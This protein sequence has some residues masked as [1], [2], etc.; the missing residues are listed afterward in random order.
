[1]DL[2]PGVAPFRVVA[3]YLVKGTHGQRRQIGGNLENA[4]P[5]DKIR[6]FDRFCE[7]IVS[8]FPSD[9]GR[10]RDG[11]SSVVYVEIT[12]VLDHGGERGGE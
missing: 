12:A 3:G 8:Q 11:L 1:V 10:C 7:R 6:R 4:A 5:T 9:D 2:V